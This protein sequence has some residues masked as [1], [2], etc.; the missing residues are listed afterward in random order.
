MTWIRLSVPR[1]VN[2]AH[3]NAAYTASVRAMIRDCE[4]GRRYAFNRT[5][6]VCAWSADSHTAVDDAVRELTATMRA[7]GEPAILSAWGCQMW[8]EGRKEP[9]LVSQTW[10]SPRGAGYYWL[11]AFRMFDL[12]TQRAE[13][14]ALE[15]REF[16][17]FHAA[18]CADAAAKG[19]V[20]GAR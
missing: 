2:L 16:V 4:L 5:P 9:V 17:P 20:P 13:V 8:A 11:S 3:Q 14:E 10:I 15:T 6:F 12:A 19:L 7:V 1:L 18:L